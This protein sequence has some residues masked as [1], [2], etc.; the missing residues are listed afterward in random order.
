MDVSVSLVY[1]N[2]IPQ[3]GGLN[4][5]FFLTVLEARIFKTKMLVES[6]HFQHSSKRNYLPKAP[7]PNT[8]TVGFRAPT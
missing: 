5:R 3:L 1:Y 7:P 6:A 2:K 4:N 8:V